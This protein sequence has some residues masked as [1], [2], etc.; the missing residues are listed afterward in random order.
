MIT[1]VTRT[2]R[3]LSLTFCPSGQRRFHVLPVLLL[4]L[5]TAIPIA[6][7]EQTVGLFQHEEAAFD[8]YTLFA[9]NMYTSTYLI[10]NEGRLIHQW[11]SEFNP[12]ASAYLLDN[13]HLLRTVRDA[14]NPDFSV[15]GAGGRVQE[16]DWDGNLVW[17]FA[18]SNDQ[19]RSHHDIE[20]LPNG[21]VLMIAWEN[22]S[23]ISR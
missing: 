17:E 16:F 8:G 7:Q 19:H 18:Y 5:V 22:K 1:V 11:E 23:P 12:G 15:G 3:S 14:E 6:A 2:L 9:P 13:G 20:K 10:D 4:I 21:N